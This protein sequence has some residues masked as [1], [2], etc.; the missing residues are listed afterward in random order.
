[1][2]WILKLQQTVQNVANNFVVRKKSCH[3]KVTLL[4]I[5]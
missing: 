4:I 1:M 5:E 3:G 2:I